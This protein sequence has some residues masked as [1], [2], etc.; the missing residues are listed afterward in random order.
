MITDISL[1]L[2]SLDSTISVNV[3]KSL[4]IILGGGYFKTPLV[5]MLYSVELWND[6]R[7]T[8]WKRLSPNGRTEVD[9][10]KPH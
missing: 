7:M 2:S 6:R 5:A 10:E 4:H 3:I 8:D 1:D 9:H